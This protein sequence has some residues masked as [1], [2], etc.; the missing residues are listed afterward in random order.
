VT[1]VEPAPPTTTIAPK[2]GKKSRHGDHGKGKGK[3]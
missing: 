3:D 1:T 2:R